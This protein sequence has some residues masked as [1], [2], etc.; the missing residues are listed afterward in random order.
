[1]VVLVHCAVEWTEDCCI[2]SIPDHVVKGGADYIET[3]VL[4]YV[5]DRAYD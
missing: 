2:G 1:M 5:L 3:S 4:D